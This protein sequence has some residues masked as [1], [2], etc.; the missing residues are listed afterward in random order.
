MPNQ[1]NTFFKSAA[2]PMPVYFEIQRM[3][4][5]K[6]ETGEWGPGDRIPTEK[7]LADTCQVS[8]GTV[9]KAVLNLVNDGF[10]YRLQGKGT[11]VKGSTLKGRLRYYRFQKDFQTEVATLKIELLDIRAIKSTADIACQLDIAPGQNI[12]AMKRLFLMQTKPVVYCISYLSAH[13]F[14]GL[15]AK[16]ASFFK[17]ATLYLA[18]EEAYAVATITNRYLLG[19]IAARADHA[20]RLNIKAGTPLLYI[21]M[22][23][24]THKEKPYEYRQSYC[25]TNRHKLFLTI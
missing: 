2:S 4:Q 22:Q 14:P 21:E 17:D 9:K 25:L 13:M 6:I 19:S 18:L 11:F 1:G 20:D 12:Y 8:V 24:L 3:L 7:E 10:L 23:S 5:D 16:P 15:D